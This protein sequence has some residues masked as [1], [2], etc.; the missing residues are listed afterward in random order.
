MTAFEL[1]ITDGK[2]LEIVDFKID[3]L[4]SPPQIKE[5]LIQ[6][7]DNYVLDQPDAFKIIYNNATLDE[8]HLNI[9][10]CQF[11]KG[12]FRVHIFGKIKGQEL[13]T[14]KEI[15]GS[16]VDSPAIIN[17]RIKYVLVNSRNI[18]KM[19]YANSNIKSIENHLMAFLIA[20]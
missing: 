10:V 8:G 18:L 15:P 17:D 12:K 16:N 14:E 6:R 3:L 2:P 7:T 13:R 19:Y 1:P 11:P 9:Y 20:A 4:S 5:E